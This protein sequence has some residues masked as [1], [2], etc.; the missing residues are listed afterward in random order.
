MHTTLFG[1]EGQ[2]PA[3]WVGEHLPK[4]LSL[5]ALGDS[6][7]NPDADEAAAIT[8]AIERVCAVS[9]TAVSL[10]SVSLNRTYAI[11]TASR[12]EPYI[13]RTP[14]DRE[15]FPGICDLS[16]EYEL[17]GRLP[18]EIQAPKPV[19]YGTVGAPI[20]GPFVLMTYVPGKPIPLG[21]RLPETFQNPSARRAIGTAL[22]DQLATLHT[23]PTEPFEA[24]CDRRSIAEGITMLRSQCDRITDERTQGSEQLQDVGAW[25]SKHAPTELEIVLNH[26]DF[27]P[28]NIHFQGTETPELTGVLDW[29]TPLLGD[30]RLDLGYL[31]FRW[32]EPGDPTVA[33]GMIDTQNAS[34]AVRE[35]ITSM[36]TDGL[37]PFTRQPGSPTRTALIERY[38]RQTG[39]TIEHERFFRVLGGFSLATVW[40]TLDRS[41]RK[42]SGESDWGPY[43][44][45]LAR[46][47]VKLTEE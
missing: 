40:A 11:E 17:L 4:Q 1:S 26:G 35:E 22:I 42:T 44:E 24:L 34:D 29:E 19:A 47:C 2:S 13:L 6:T 9:V 45:W 46:F 27:R 32:H 25:L 5:R 43:I 16:T 3:G 7:V 23:Q 30:P 18:A 8:A 28:G 21:D 33:P 15:S 38:E 20:D 37:A 31:C 39:T 12:D 10:L 14:I 41:A 36:T